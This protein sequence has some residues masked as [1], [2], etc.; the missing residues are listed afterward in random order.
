MSSATPAQLIHINQMYLAGGLSRAQFA[1]FTRMAA[2]GAVTREIAQAIAGG[3]FQ[4]ESV[5][6]EAYQA[7]VHAVWERIGQRVFGVTFNQYLNGTDGLEAIP[8][9]PSWP[10]AYGT[11]FDR[12][13]LVD[14]RVIEKIGLAET[15]LLA[16]LVCRERNGTFVAYKPEHAKMGVRWEYAQAGH[17][18]R[19]REVADCRMAFKEYEVGMAADEGIFTYLDNPTV[20]ERH[21]LDLTGSVH[22]EDDSIYACLGVFDGRRELRRAYEGMASR[23]YGTATRAK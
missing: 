4:F 23:S 3:R 16:E 15:C 2:A 20:I 11:T 22:R 5:L 12:V 1:E 13:V 14:G 18:N 21:C 6:S 8:M 19:G 9:L 7:K 10:S 17:K